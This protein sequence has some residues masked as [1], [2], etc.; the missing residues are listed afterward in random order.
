[1]PRK[2]IIDCDP[3]IDDAAALCL[4]MFDA[5]L[6]VVAVTAVAG[7]VSP[8]AASRNAQVIIDQLD[9]A[10]FPRVGTASRVDDAPAVDGTQM[11]GEDGLGNAGYEVAPLHH[12]HQS[13]KIISDEVQAAPDEITLICLGPL[14]NIARALKRD[15]EVTS[16]INRILI[17]GGSVGVGGNVTPAAEFNIYGDPNSAR[18]VF[19]SRTT[20]TLIPLDVT[21]QVAFSMAM[22]DELPGDETRAGRLLRRILPFSFRAHHQLLG[23]EVIQLHGLVTILS[24]L[25]P[26]LFEM[27]EMAGDVEIRGSLTTGATIFD[28]RP[29][30]FWRTNM[31]VAVEIDVNAA[32]DAI[33]RGLQE[34]GRRT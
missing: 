32:R 29:K 31:D 15:P 28:R 27:K 23:Q 22:M 30:P 33:V 6:D 7:N 14:T 9:P 20:K 2:V 8:E 25:R 17:G 34:A 26:E 11:H 13:D 10:R 19:R 5:Q 4:A 12:Q 24:V 1:M 21:Q 3:G 16:S 18:T